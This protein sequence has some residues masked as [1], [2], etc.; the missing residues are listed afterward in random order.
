MSSTSKVRYEDL[1]QF[2]P[3][4]ESQT[5]VFDL[6][7]DDENIIMSGS[8]GTGK[9]FLAMYL[10]LE[11]VLDSDTPQDQVIILR[12][13]VPTR[14]MG[15]LPGKLE[16]KTATFEAPYK[17]IADE[18]FNDKA[19]YNK[20]VNNHLVKFETTSFIR[21]RTFDR[22]VIVVDEMQNLNFHELDSVMTR[23]GEHTR[24]IFCG[25]YVQSDFKTEGDRLGIMKFMSIIDRMTNFS[26]VNFTWEDIVRSGV[27]RD[28]IMTKE[29]MG[30]R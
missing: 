19:S 22:S 23:V 6:W 12:S 18:L 21:G 20:L 7:D 4:T 9:T 14:E 26:T 30:L 2:D 15:F 11:A 29:L 24:I 27:V 16:E 5:K 28:Y 25:D 8:A 10:A 3:I 1:Y 17:A 13:V